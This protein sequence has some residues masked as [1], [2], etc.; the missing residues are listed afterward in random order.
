MNKVL[1]LF[2]KNKNY[3]SVI[4]VFSFYKS[5]INPDIPKY[6]KLVFDKM[7]ISINQVL[8]DKLSHAQFLNHITRTVTNTDY[9]VFF[10]IDCIPTRKEWLPVLLNDLLE[11][12]DSIVGAAQTANFDHFK[13]NIYVSPFFVGISTQY[14]KKLNYPDATHRYDG[15]TDDYDVWQNITNII[16][17]KGGHVKYWWPT[18]IEEEKWYLHHPQ[19]NK[20]GL[21]TTYNDMIY[22][23]FFSRTDSSERFVKKCKEVLDSL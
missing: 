22:H 16:I 23:A 1:N 2:K 10:D 19:H 18:H 6:Q 4:E 7:G 13:E 15:T 3:R 21:G 8:N 12:K 9:L 5:N 20:F 14:L 17:S 11:S